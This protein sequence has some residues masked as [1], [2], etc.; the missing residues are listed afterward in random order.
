[1]KKSNVLQIVA[2][3]LL[4]PASAMGQGSN[5]TVQEI[6]NQVNSDTLVSLVR[7]L[8]GEDSVI[9][10]STKVLIPSRNNYAPGNSLAGGFIRQ[11]ILRQ[12]LD[13]TD[14]YY[15]SSGRNVIGT[16]LGTKYPGRQIVIGAHYD[17]VTD[18]AAD[19]N[20]S[21][22]AAV[23]E[24]AR[25]LSKYQLDYT[26]VYVLFDEE[27]LGLIGSAAYAAAAS[28]RGDTILW[29]V[30]MDMIG[31]D[32][33]DDGLCN[34]HSSIVGQSDSLA[35]L[36]ISVNQW[37]GL[38]LTPLA[39]NPSTSRSDHASFWNNS[40]TA[41]LLIEAYWG[42]TNDF[43]SYYHS[44]SDRVGFFNVPYFHS[45]ARLAIGTVATLAVANPVV[46]VARSLSVVPE[47]FAV[48]SYPNPFNGQARITYTVPHPTDVSIVIYN[49][50][51]KEI[52][53][54]VDSRPHRPGQYSATFDAMGLPSGVYLA[55]F[56]A[57]SERRLHKLVL[58]R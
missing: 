4:L 19:D 15:T 53:R 54:L 34:I 51:G 42:G 31:W 9:L 47:G 37:Y 36:M 49:V 40:Y 28:A 55:M 3:L 27:E 1:M 5:P 33:D 43:N 38:G 41:V 10:N 56:R 35:S 12:G 48:A 17:A 21:G 29:M 25:V 8:T 23:L 57:G 26:V 13:A 30:N 32:N 52:A 45:M 50:L 46:S 16:Q 18:Y 44:S 39:Y 58:V 24:A 2:V 6:L 7:G 14:M 11:W 22:V 20:A